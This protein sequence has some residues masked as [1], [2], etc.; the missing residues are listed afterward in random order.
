MSMTRSQAGKLGA[1]KTKRLWRNRYKENPKQ[2]KCCQKRLPYE[3]RHNKFC[4]QSCSA[5][6]SNV[7]RSKC[8][9]TV[10]VQM[11]QNCKQRICDNKN[12]K[13]KYCSNVCQFQHKWE[14]CKR[15]I[16][17]GEVD[18]AKSLK[19]YLLETRGVECEICKTK[20][21]QNQPVPLVMDHIDGNSEH[22]SLENLRLVCGNC[23]MQLSTYKS[24]NIGRGRHYRRQRYAEGK[25]F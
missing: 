5:S 19:R 24:K 22:N 2:C 4:N 7:K 1:E 25:S 14:N 3:K 20:E 15:L 9:D 8:D 21:W 11:C 6:F 16:E 10:Q 23:D 18:S 17:L 13:R 12:K